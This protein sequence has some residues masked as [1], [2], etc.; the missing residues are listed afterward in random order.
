MA[1]TMM[2]TQMLSAV[3]FLQITLIATILLNANAARQIIGFVYLTFV[4]GFAILR[5][6]RLK[7]EKVET[8]VLT[9]GLS[10]GFLMAE[11]LFLNILGP[12]LGFSSFALA[13]LLIVTSVF[14]DVSFAIRVPDFDT[15]VSFSV[16]KKEVLLLG[17]FAVGILALSVFGAI[18]SG[19]DP[20]LSRL[21]LITMFVGIASVIGMAALFKDALPA[22]FFPVVLFVAALALLLHQSLSSSNLFGGDIF[23]EYSLFQNTLSNLHWDSVLQANYNSMMSITVLPTIYSVVLNIGGTWLFKIVYP[24]LFAFVPLGLYTL[25]EHKFSREI[26]FFSVFLF[27]SYLTFYSEMLGLARQMIAEIFFVVLFIVMFSP[28]IKGFGKWFLFSLFCFGLIV[29]H[30]SLSYIFLGSIFAVW[31]VSLLWKQTKKVTVAM[32]ILFAVMAFAWFIYTSSA[33]TFSNFTSVTDTLRSHFMSDLFNPQSRGTEVLQAVGTTG[34]PSLWHTLGKY[35]FYSV[36]GSALIGF[37]GPLVRKRLSIFRED[38]NV[39]GVFSI[40]LLG[41]CIVVP[42]FSDTFNLTRFFHTALFFLAPFCIMGGIELSR[43]LSRRAW[44]K[45]WAPLIVFLVLIPFFFFQNGAVYELAKDQSSSL[46]LS[47]YRIDSVTLGQYG[48]FPQSDFS[49]AVWISRFKSISGLVFADLN[50]GSIFS[51]VSAPWFTV[52][53]RD[54]NFTAGSLVYFAQFNLDSKQIF[55][56]FGLQFGDNLTDVDLSLGSSNT[57]YSTGDCEVLQVPY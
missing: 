8:V 9:V 49:G 28:R 38:F 39:L 34:I 47:R 29:S 51:Y 22:K 37:L 27:I 55:A 25:F 12:R 10:L 41:A 48:V 21:I 4:P 17:I 23:G 30:Y 11:G 5:L 32:I 6:L 26:A 52:L 31:I 24:L 40:I 42:Y 36:I 44:S 56:G 1:L 16:R 13:P 35:V 7:L 46:P 3:V 45:F 50:S 33:S 15:S 43:I 57:V 19:G 18:M 54:N 53:T 14:V 20:G 2:R